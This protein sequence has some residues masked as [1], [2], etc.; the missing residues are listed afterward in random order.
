MGIQPCSTFPGVGEQRFDLPAFDGG[1]AG[2]SARRRHDRL[3]ARRE[4]SFRRRF[5]LIGGLLYRVVPEPRNVRAWSSGSEGESAIGRRL[6]CLSHI[7]VTA[8]HDRRIPRTVANIDHIAIGPAGVY[9]IDT[10]RY[11]GARVKKDY[12][13]PM[14]NPGPAQLF[15]RG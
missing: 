7:G 12:L 15:V 14:W 8:L 3:A 9:V 11:Q 4:Q 5:P 6:D 2:R 13:G 10:K 1:V